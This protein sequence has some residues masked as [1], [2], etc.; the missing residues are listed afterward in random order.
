LAR[1]RKKKP[2][3]WPGSSIT[4]Q[5]RLLSPH[6]PVLAFAQRDQILNLVA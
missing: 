4:P 3:A 6:L 1:H 2:G 5:H